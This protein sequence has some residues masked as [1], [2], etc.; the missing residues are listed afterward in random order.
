[1]LGHFISPVSGNATSFP[2]LGKSLKGIEPLNFPVGF[3]KFPLA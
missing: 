3:T 1:M 2:T